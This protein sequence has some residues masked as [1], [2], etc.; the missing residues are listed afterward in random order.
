MT[1]VRLSSKN[2]IVVPAKARKQLG[3]KP[4][5]TL[6]VHVREKSIVLIPEPEDYVES[7]RGLGKHVWADID[8]DEWLRSERESWEK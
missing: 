8:T 4:G 3:L 2:Q 7:L 1:K 5:D 6:L